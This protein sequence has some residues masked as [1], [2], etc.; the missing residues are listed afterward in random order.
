MSITSKIHTLNLNFQNIN[1]IH[2]KKRKSKSKLFFTINCAIFI[3][4]ALILLNS[5][6][7]SFS[8]L[9]RSFLETLNAHFLNPKEVFYCYSVLTKADIFFKLFFYILIRRIS[10]VSLN[11]FKN[12]IME[13][14]DVSLLHW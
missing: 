7:F 1:H 4:N 11:L 13:F 8:L 12:F 2:S 3:L 10:K 6:I 9:S 5:H 14:Y